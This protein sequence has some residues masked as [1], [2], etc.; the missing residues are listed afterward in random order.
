MTPDEATR[1]ARP[2]ALASLPV[3]GGEV[4]LYEFDLGYVAWAK[5]PPSDPARPPEVIG[6]P[7]AVVDK[8]TGELSTWPSLSPQDV[9]GLYELE[10]AARRRFPDEVRRVLTEAGW[11]SDRNVGAWVAS[12]LRDVYAADPE[13]GQR[14]PIFPAA[15]VLLEE[16]GGLAFRQLKKPGVGTSGYDVQ[17][18]PLEGRVR[19]DLFTDFGADLGVPVFP[20]AWYEDGPSDLAIAADGRVFLLH[21]AGEFL[22]GA[23]P[24]EA[25][26]NLVRGER[27][28]PVDEYG[29]L[30][31]G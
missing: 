11:R 31:E 2:W 28:P 22:V 17:F 19:T 10:M 1:I 27:F 8:E 26:V 6:A 21:E 24:D 5:V 15:R 20:V 30:V 7:L 13:T 16:F 29:E 3:S 18:W 23:T 9:A 14:L 25:I 4:G 12:W